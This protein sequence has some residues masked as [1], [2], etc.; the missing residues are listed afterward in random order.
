MPVAIA[1]NSR[2]D[3]MFYDGFE[4]YS[5]GESLNGANYDSCARKHIDFSTVQDAQVASAESL[6]VNAH[7]GKY[8][9]MISGGKTAIKSIPVNNNIPVDQYFLNYKTN[10]VNQLNEGGGNYSIL[11][12]SPNTTYLRYHSF[13]DFGSFVSTQFNTPYSTFVGYTYS[14]QQ[15]FQ[16]QTAGTYSFFLEAHRISDFSNQT[17]GGMLFQIISTSTGQAVPYSIFTNAASGGNAR[18]STVQICLPVGVYS[19]VCNYSNSQ[20]NFCSGCTNINT[21]DSYGITLNNNVNNILSYKSLSAQASCIYTLPA[22]ASDSMLNPTGAI[23]SN[24]KMVFSAWVKETCGN[25]QGGIPCTT[26]SYTNNEVQIDFG[27]ATPT[28]LKPTGPIIEGWQRYEGYFTAPA[29]ASAMNLKLVN[30]SSNPIYFDDIR[31]HPFNSNMKSY[32]YDPVNLR[33]T[34]ELDANNYASFYEYDEEGTLIRTKVETKEGVK[35]VTESR[36]AKQK[37]ITDF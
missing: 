4:D 34:S 19:M 1:N 31:I 16:V 28:V 21:Y 29:G 22:P 27:V 13:S 30:N 18:Y 23:P 37:N 8:L 3:E 5:Y 9:M 26:S 7:S 6:G 10:S 24:K 12:E 32:V 35:T 36:S 14:T 11:G 33:L 2:N 20:S 17:P 25:P 15:Y